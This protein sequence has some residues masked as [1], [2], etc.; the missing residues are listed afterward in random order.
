MGPEPAA[1]TRA[2]VMCTVAIM[3][4]SL[5]LSAYAGT[6]IENTQTVWYEA[7]EPFWVKAIAYGEDEGWYLS[8]WDADMEHGDTATSPPPPWAWCSYDYD[9]YL[10]WFAEEVVR[11]TTTAWGNVTFKTGDPPE[12]FTAETFVDARYQ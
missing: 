12:S 4:A 11:I 8:D 2:A 1:V 3:I 9:W 10:S 5:V 6:P 7:Y